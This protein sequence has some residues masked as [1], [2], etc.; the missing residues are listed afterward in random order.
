MRSTLIALVTVCLLT[1][2]S[3]PA[4]AQMIGLPNPASTFCVSTGGT[5]VITDTGAGETGTCVYDSGLAVDEWALFNFF[6][7]LTDPNQW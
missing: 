2:G 1:L 7:L 4:G 5:L 6:S 3:L